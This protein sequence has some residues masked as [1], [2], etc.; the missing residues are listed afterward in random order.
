MH[1]LGI[2]QEMLDIV[3]EQARQNSATR[4]HGVRLKVGDLSGVVPEALQFAFDVVT[5]GTLAEGATLELIPVPVTC[6]CGRC[7]RIFSPDGPVHRCPECGSLEAHTVAGEE[8]LLES[9]EMTSD[10]AR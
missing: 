9:I 2:L 1:E 8:L 7:E 3:L 4:V 5:R 6:Y 10:V